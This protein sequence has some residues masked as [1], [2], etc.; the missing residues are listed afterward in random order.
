MGF[1]IG[2]IKLLRLWWKEP[3]TKF[4]T[5][6]WNQWTRPDESLS[7]D[8]IKEDLEEEEVFVNRRSDQNGNIIS[9]FPLAQRSTIIVNI[10][11]DVSRIKHLTNA[12][13]LKW[14]MVMSFKIYSN[15][16]LRC[17]KPKL[18]GSLGHTKSQGWAVH[19]LPGPSVVLF[20]K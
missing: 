3:M 16:K 8:S 4:S 15:F 18:P 19:L 13:L 14:L 2:R 12:S 5:E 6:R 10:F 1:S 7:S 20:I 9:P 17:E 11:C